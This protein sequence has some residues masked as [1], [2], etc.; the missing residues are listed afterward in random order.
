MSSMV[1]SVIFV[2]LVVAFLQC[3][4]KAKRVMVCDIPQID[5]AVELWELPDYTQV[6]IT[7]YK[8]WIVIKSGKSEAKEFLIDE[9]YISYR[10][11]RVFISE[12]YNAI[13]IETS[14]IGKDE[15]H[16]IAEYLVGQ[17]RF[18]ARSEPTVYGKKG[19]K[20]LKEKQIH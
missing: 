15:T 10:L 4:V 17:E 14:S 9:R 1:K 7:E 3:G 5:M 8:T 2:I 19:W 12:D 6:L 20:L 18:S 13:R 11:T 16:L